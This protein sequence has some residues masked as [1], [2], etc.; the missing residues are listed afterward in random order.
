[1]WHRYKI[2]IE[3][4]G[5]FGASIPHTEDEIKKMLLYRMPE[6]KP[7][8]GEWDASDLDEVA[9]K[10]ATDRNAELEAD[11]PEEGWLPGWA[12]F[13]RDENGGIVYE[14]RCIRG[15]LKD[16]AFGIKDMDGVKGTKNFR[17]KFV[18]RVYIERNKNDH[19]HLHDANG[20][21]IIEPTDRQQRFIQVMTRQGPRSTIKYVDY[22]LDPRMT[23]VVKLLDDGVITNKHL[24]MVLEYGGTHG[25]GAERS[26]G[27][28]TYTV[29]EI[30]KIK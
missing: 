26:Q 15:H 29:T 4:D 3:I 20:E 10:I 5:Q 21:R 22:V 8:S 13:L 16:S 25:I 7:G 28:G 14:G 23:F 11:E 6:N 27:W 18:Q 17:A 30:K 9:K 24:G 19:I 12:G 1:M 2:S